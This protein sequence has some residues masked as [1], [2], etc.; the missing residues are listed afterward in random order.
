MGGG[1]GARSIMTLFPRKRESITVGESRNSRKKTSDAQVKTRGTVRWT[2]ASKSPHP[3]K[4]G[5][6][7]SW[8]MTRSSQKSSRAASKSRGIPA[9]VEYSGHVEHVAS[10]R[11]QHVADRRC[12]DHAADFHPAA[13]A[14][15]ARDR[16]SECRF[17]WMNTLPAPPRPFRRSAS[18]TMAKGRR[19]EG[20]FVAS[21][22][23]ARYP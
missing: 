11:P 21:D 17:V 5:N 14:A 1:G 22:D 20:R 12:D 16:M 4:R 9:R 8:V 13:E 19:G 2:S 18:C 7:A 3:T 10:M 15:S 23:C 6:P